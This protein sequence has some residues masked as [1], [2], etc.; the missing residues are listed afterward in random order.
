MKPAKDLD[1]L[2]ILQ[3]YYNWFDSN[4]DYLKKDYKDQYVAVKVKK[5]IDNDSD[6][7]RLVKRL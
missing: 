3:D 4:Y 1:K 6:I 5:Q 2:E 7:H